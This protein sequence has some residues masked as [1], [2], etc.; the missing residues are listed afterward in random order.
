MVFLT[1]FDET[2]SSSF[3]WSVLSCSR[4]LVNR[5]ATSTGTAVVSGSLPLHNHLLP[6]AELVV[7]KID[8]LLQGIYYVR[9]TLPIH[10]LVKDSAKYIPGIRSF[11]DINPWPIDLVGKFTI[12]SDLAF[13]VGL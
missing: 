7:V 6:R 13:R 9:K 8:I 2:R 11:L 4:S 1:Y 10:F 5:P 3:K 12:F